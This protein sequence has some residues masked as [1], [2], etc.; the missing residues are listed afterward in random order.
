MK[1]DPKAATAPQKLIVRSAV[2][3]AS[4]R[5]GG[6]EPVSS[7]VPA[8]R[9]DAPPEPEQEQ[10]DEHHRR[11]VAGGHGGDGARLRA[12]PL[13]DAITAHGADPVDE[14]A[15]DGASPNM[16]RMCTAITNADRSACP[17][18][19]M[20]GGVIAITATIAACAPAIDASPSD[21]TGRPP[22]HPYDA[23]TWRD[24]PRT[25]GVR[26]RGAEDHQWI[27]AEAGEHDGGADQEQGGAEHKRTDSSSR[28]T[29]RA[30]S[31][32]TA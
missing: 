19:F 22:D 16:P 18:S 10:A 17:W 13:R 12:R 7:E 31:F 5:V 15:D 4:T 24:R 14:P 2:P 32:S 8:I 6:T 30:K 28:P 3:C 27:R 29:R 26:V 21:R 25:L 9:H 1:P 11:H 20:C 23:C